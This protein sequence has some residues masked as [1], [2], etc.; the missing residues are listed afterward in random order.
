[1][2][3]WNRKQFFDEIG[4]LLCN[5]RLTMPQRRGLEQK[6]TAFERYDIADDRW[7][8]YMLATSFHET[9]GTMLPV[10]EAGRGRG[11]PYG[12]KRK[13]D[14]TLYHVPDRI[15]YGRGDVQLTWYENYERMG[16]LLRLP[17]LEQPELALMPEISA[18]IMI[19][20]MTRGISARGDFTGLALE[21]FFN[22]RRD[23]PLQARKVVNGM[24]RAR[25]IAQYHKHFL[26][27]LRNT[28]R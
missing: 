4:R 9:A 15:Y 28:T 2:M 20:G 16:Q 5:G 12:E 27:A 19:E 14:G 24:D 10:E 23:D 7:R 21:D 17:L 25:L 11:R 18:R 3:R 13:R 1:M 26:T 6:L 8:A 22:D